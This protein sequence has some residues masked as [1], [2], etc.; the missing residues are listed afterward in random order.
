MAEN[1][2]GFLLYADLIHT[3]RKM[4]K[5]KAGELFVTILEYVNDENP[6]VNDM[7]VDLVFEP[8]KRQ[9]KRDLEKYEGKKTQW[10]EAGKASAEAKRLAKEEKKRLTD[11]T[12]V[13][14][15]ATDLTV[16][17]ND[18]VN[19]N[20]TV[21]DTVN[22]I[23]KKEIESEKKIIIEDNP[24]EVEAKKE[25]EKSAAKKEKEPEAAEVMEYPSFNDF[26][27]EYDKKQDRAACERK[28]LKLPQKDK[29]AIM[30]HL[31]KYKISQPDKAFRKNPETY[32]NNKSW[33]NEIIIKN[34]NT[35]NE[36]KQQNESNDWDR[37]K[38][39]I[40]FNALQDQTGGH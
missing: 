24:A 30:G 29:E 26:W 12:D 33:E 8:I 25:K 28:W 5:D 27:E 35:T 1:K 19:V 14:N 22:G 3:V 4:P 37:L 16:N 18:T 34:G 6:V 38:Q 32:L 39:G 13:K 10:S 40:I 15:V 17:V 7:L 11:S 36:T 31:P 20:V 21:N 23:N 2:K 9:L